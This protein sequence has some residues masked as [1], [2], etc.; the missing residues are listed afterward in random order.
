MGAGIISKYYFVRV[1][2]PGWFYFVR[3]LN[4][5]GLVLFCSYTYLMW[6]TAGRYNLLCSENKCFIVR[7]FSEH[8]P[9][10]ILISLKHENCGQSIGQ[11]VCRVLCTPLEAGRV[12]LRQGIRP[13]LGRMGERC[14]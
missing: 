11:K 1:L 3:T 8:W 5:P 2:N 10:P 13:V 4:E 14:I 7:R 9:D 12:G 6:L